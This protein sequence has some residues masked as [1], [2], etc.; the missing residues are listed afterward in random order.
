MKVVRVSTKM[1]DLEYARVGSIE[2]AP[3]VIVEQ[4]SPG[5]Y[6]LIDGYHRMATARALGYSEVNAIVVDEAD[7][8]LCSEFGEGDMT[9]EEWIEWVES[10]HD[11]KL[12]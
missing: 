6:D 8:D 9:E 5:S 2:D 12:V 4:I 11:V 3:A 7:L 1:A 10:N